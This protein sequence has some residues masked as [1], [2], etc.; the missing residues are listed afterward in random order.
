MGTGKSVV[1]RKVSQYL[2]MDFI[3][4][5]EVITKR[6]NKPINQIFKE[7][8]EEYFRDLEK[9]LIEELS[10][11]NNLVVSCGGGVVL[12]ENNVKRLKE[13]GVMICLWANPQA[14]YDR[15]KA[16]KHRP[17][18]NVSNPKAEIEELLDYRRPFYEK[19]DHHIDTSDLSI[20]EVVDEVLSIARKHKE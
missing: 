20:E 9:D 15:V 7:E 3:E 10:Q 8:G 19:A 16:Q 12:D 14:I 11:E 18:L 1:G 4:M 6:E 5:D 2:R 17:L 13:S